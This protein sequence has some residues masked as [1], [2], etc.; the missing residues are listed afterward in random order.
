MIVEDWKGQAFSVLNKNVFVRDYVCSSQPLSAMKGISMNAY[1]PGVV[2]QI[3][4]VLG[5]KK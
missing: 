5:F 4:G 3:E 1:R 2:H